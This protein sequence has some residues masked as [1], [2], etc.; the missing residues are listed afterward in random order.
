M[1]Y[2]VAIVLLLYSCT[3][4]TEV[5]QNI[6]TTASNTSSSPLGVIATSTSSP[7]S[8]TPFIE[9]QNSIN[10]CIL[11]EAG[12]VRGRI[13]LNDKP[14]FDGA[15]V[16]LVPEAGPVLDTRSED[17]Y[18]SFPLLGRKCADGLHWVGFQLR[19]AHGGKNIKP[20]RADLEINFEVR[21]SEEVN[22]P[23]KNPSCQL[24]MGTISG[25]VIVNGKPAPDGTIVLAALGD[26]K[27]TLERALQTVITKDGYYT[28][29]SPGNR[30]G[31]RVSFLRWTL[32]SLGT[33][34]TVMPTS[35]NTRLDI[36]V[37]P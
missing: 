6:K 12:E 2:L 24:T 20:D 31:E 8:S 13:Y 19:A 1:R 32:S 14:L 16:S 17:G 27:V 4:I 36:I 7:L 29:S 10:L 21:T 15:M 30:C 35:E 5:D 22:L 11:E 28:L 25:N 9:Q 26:R 18:Y 34:V 3:T 37:S 23:P 33:E